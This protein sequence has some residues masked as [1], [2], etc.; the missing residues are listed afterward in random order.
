M[1]ALGGGE[2]IPEDWKAHIGDDIVTI[3]INRGSQGR[4]IPKTCTELC[5]RVIRQAPHVLFANGGMAELIAGEDRIPDG[6]FEAFLSNARYFTV[7]DSVK[8]NTLTFESTFLTATVSYDGDPEIAPGEEK[9]LKISFRNHTGEY[10]N[11]LYNLELRWWLPEGFCVEGCAKT[12]RLPHYTAHNRGVGAPFEVAIKAGEQV[13]ALNRCVLEVTAV[14]R[15]IP[16]Y[17]PI[18]LLG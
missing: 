15:S 1:V 5:E 7:L 12:Y 18:V 3:S 10:D 4:G 16:M 17:I 8:P 13:E 2:I 14:G 9:K 6:V 11:K